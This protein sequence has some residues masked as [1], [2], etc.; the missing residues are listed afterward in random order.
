MFTDTTPKYIKTLKAYEHWT[1]RRNGR[2]EVHTVGVRMS[3]RW[4]E[5]L[6]FKPDAP[7]YV[8]TNA[9]GQLILSPT[10][11]FE[12]A[13]PIGTLDE[14]KVKFAELNIPTTR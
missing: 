6:G 3:G 10:P 5:Q 11:L 2:R 14:L 12:L 8:G 1:P 13:I 4:L 9:Q 7:V